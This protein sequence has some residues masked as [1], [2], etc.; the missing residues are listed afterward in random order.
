[1]LSA[2]FAA[3]GVV[4]SF[5][6]I[7]WLMIVGCVVSFVARIIGFH[8]LEEILTPLYRVPSWMSSSVVLLIVTVIGMFPVHFLLDK[9]FG[10]SFLLSMNGCVLLVYILWPFYALVQFV[11]YKHYNK[12]MY[13]EIQREQEEDDGGF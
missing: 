3:A 2:A 8:D 4:A 12:M 11:K 1:M 5:E 13:R 9:N 10:S 6:N 7:T